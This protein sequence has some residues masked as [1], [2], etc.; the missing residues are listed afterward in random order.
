MT[1]TKQPKPFEAITKGM[2]WRAYKAVKANG[3]AGGV[4]GKSIEDFESDLENNLY[5]IWNRLASGSYFPP[6]VLSVSIPKANGGERILGIPTVGDRVAQT[7]VK[8]Y[9]EP[10]LEQVFH[11]DSYG[12]RPGRSAHDAIGTVRKRCWKYDWLL[13]FDIKGLFDNICHSLLMKAV[14][15]HV[16]DKWVL[17]YIRRWLTAP[18]SRNGEETLRTKGTPQGGVVSPVA[19]NLFLHYAFDLWMTRK[20][21][22]APFARYADDGVVHCCSKQEAQEIR[23]C[24]EERLADVGLKLHPDKTKIIYCKD[25]SRKGG[26]GEEVTFDFLGYTF[27]PRESRDRKGESFT[28]FLPAISRKAKKAINKVIR[29]WGVRRRSD[30]TLQEIAKFCNPRIRGWINYYGKYYKSALHVVLRRL[31][32]ALINW[33]QRTLKSL[34][35]SHRRANRWLKGFARANPKLFAH[36]SQFPP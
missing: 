29:D 30:L 32:G 3:G 15:W 36:W 21:P 13:E 2:V 14:R 5:K 17:L 23:K 31:N 9:I 27:M 26:E 20:F 8:Q 10:K 16:K 22:R 33:A 34:K 28:G 19:S 6:P 12:Y 7:V 24:L 35:R 4:D 1:S 11:P 25:S 18:M